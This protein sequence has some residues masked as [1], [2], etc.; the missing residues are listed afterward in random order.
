MNE[1]SIIINGFRYDAVF[2]EN[3]EDAICSNCDLRYFC[4]EFVLIDLCTFEEDNPN[5]VY[6]SSNKKFER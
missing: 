1:V 4:R 6:K 2:L 5:V 3:E